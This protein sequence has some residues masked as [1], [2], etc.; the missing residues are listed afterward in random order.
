MQLSTPKSDVLTQLSKEM[1]VGTLHVVLTC[2]NR[3]RRNAAGSLRLGALTGSVEE[4]ASAWIDRVSGATLDIE[5]ERLYAGEYW[6]A[7]MALR[8]TARNR[9]DVRVWVLSAGF[10]LI[11][12]SQRICA[13]GATFSSGHPD[14]VVSHLNGKPVEQRH[15]WWTALSAWMGPAGGSGPRTLS[16]LAELDPSA[17]VIVCAGHDYLDAVSQDLLK[18]QTRLASSQQLVIFGA[19]PHQLGLAESWVATPGRLRTRLG[20]SM[21]SVSVRAARA[22]VAVC[23]SNAPFLAGAARIVVDALAHVCEPLPTFERKRLDDQ[24]IREWIRGDARINP[25]ATKS[26]ALRRL[27]DEGMACE[28][29]RFGRLFNT[30]LSG[31]R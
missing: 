18:A 22:A 1:R 3:K 17:S 28:Q 13:Y 11:G 16:A 20:G 31:E 29:S 9:F 2:T 7:G 19:G 15:E 27:R 24:D 4:R 8:G 12:V 14:S 6:T 26:S 10:G 30:A 5:A 21:S 23:P 25:S